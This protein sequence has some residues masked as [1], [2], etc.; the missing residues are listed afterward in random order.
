ME[1]H[2]II[3][4]PVFSE[5]VYDL[6]VDQNKILFEVHKNANKFQIKQAVQE[7]YNNVTVEHVNT[8]ITPRGRKRAIV[9]LAKEYKASDLAAD[10]NLF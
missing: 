8:L 5:S 6:I 9:Q 7:L 1:A 4:R 3:I 10:L 2:E